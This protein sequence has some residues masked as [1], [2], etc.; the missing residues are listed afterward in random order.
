MKSFTETFP[1]LKNEEA[2]LDLWQFI[3]VGKI[4]AKPDMSELR[5]Y[6]KSERLIKIQSCA[7]KLYER[8]SVENST[9]MKQKRKS[10][11]PKYT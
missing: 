7:I 2:F 9:K 10:R 1:T 5:V 11:P 6:I 3:S 4:S 8:Y